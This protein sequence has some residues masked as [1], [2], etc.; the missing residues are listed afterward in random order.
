MGPDFSERQYEYAVNFELTT[1][2]SALLVGG[3]A[4]IPTT[5][6]E[7]K[8]GYDAVYN[9][10]SGYLYHLQYKVASF[11]SRRTGKNPAQWASHGGSY[12]RFPLLADSSGTC[13]QHLKLEHLRSRERAVYYCAPAF[14]RDE[15]FWSHAA[16]SSV[17][18]NSVLI[19]VAEVSLPSPNAPHAISF[20]LAGKVHL[21]S[22]PGDGEERDRD[23]RIRREQPVREFSRQT[24]TELLHELV[25]A[26]SAEES[27]AARVPRVAA[28]SGLRSSIIALRAP[29]P[30]REE[31]RRS[32]DW[33][34]EQQAHESFAEVPRDRDRREAAELA[35]E[36]DEHELLI[37]AGRIAALDFGV[38]TVVEPV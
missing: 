15:D 16:T 4:T 33:D 25:D 12:Y 11:A 30:L 31:G 7:A 24:F 5:N 8:K 17:F 27:I 3:L 23:P 9:L 35:A 26:L 1:D 13:R 14:H 28:G 38:M 21:W 19:D 37:T 10:G 22:D 6:E 18:D 34:S 32:P 29:R 20:D 2:L 36:L